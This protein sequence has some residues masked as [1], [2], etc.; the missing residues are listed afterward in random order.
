[1]DRR[2]RAAGRQLARQGEQVEYRGSL[3]F[4]EDEVILCLFAASSAEV[5][6][7]LSTA[8]TLTY[9]RIVETTAVGVGPNA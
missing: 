3:L 2:L 7:R 1:L 6:R 5:V 8:A 4:P 9:E